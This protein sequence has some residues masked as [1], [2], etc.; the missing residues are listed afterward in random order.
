MFL[1]VLLTCLLAGSWQ[2]I[3]LH[4]HFVKVECV[5]FVPYFMSERASLYWSSI[6]L[7]GEY[8]PTRKKY[9]FTAGE[10]ECIHLGSLEGYNTHSLGCQFMQPDPVSNSSGKGALLL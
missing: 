1:I 9:R 5:K 3:L 6:G 4:L 10:V 2:V 7:L 8:C